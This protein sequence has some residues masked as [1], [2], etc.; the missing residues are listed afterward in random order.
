MHNYNAPGYLNH[1]MSR[2]LFLFIILCVVTV[3]SFSI[4]AFI[5]PITSPGPMS[6]VEKAELVYSRA[7]KLYDQ[8]DHEQF[9][10]DLV[11]V[12]SIF[13]GTETAEKSLKDLAAYYLE[14]K[15]TE[16]AVYY[17]KRV[18]EEYPGSEDVILIRGKIEKIELSKLM[19]PGETE[20]ILVYTVKSG[21]SLY[22]IAKRFNTTV[23]LIKKMNFL[24]G[25]VIHP[26]QKLKVNISRFSIF[27][28]KSDNIL[29]LK[30][31]NVDFKTYIISTGKDNST[32]VGMFTIV[33][34]MIKPPWQKPGGGLIMPDDENYELG[35]RWMPIDLKGYGIHGT[36]D[37][38]TIGRQ[39]TSGCVRMKNEEVIELFNIVPRGTRVEIVD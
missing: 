18:L 8:G 5:R 23:E 32:P 25:D 17:Y 36:N 13:E 31:D 30:K 35:A 37:E 28:D 20:D 34:K 39:I 15:D 1:I 10:N 7:K 9:V 19:D 22:A 21:D 33:D 4:S 11:T 24:K 16:K 27:V 26:G 12:V 14:Q 6:K 38:S 3:G 2:K 29:I